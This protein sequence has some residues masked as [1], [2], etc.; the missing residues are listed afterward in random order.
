MYAGVGIKQ[1]SSSENLC[2]SD[3]VPSLRS[4]CECEKVQVLMTEFDQS[5]PKQVLM[6]HKESVCYEREVQ[7]VQNYFYMYYSFIEIS[8]RF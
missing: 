5:D 3:G 4:Q 1:I 6:D 2:T 8:N 7:R